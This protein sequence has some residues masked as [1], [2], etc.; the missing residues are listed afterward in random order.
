M[1]DRDLGP[2]RRVNLLPLGLL[3]VALAVGGCQSTPAPEPPS[4]AAPDPELAPID[5]EGP[6]DPDRPPPVLPEVALLLGPYAGIELTITARRDGSI[7]QAVISKPSQAKLYDEYT[8]KWVED[9]WKMPAA[10]PGEPEVREFVA[11]IV[12]PK[13]K[14]PSGGDYPLPDYPE[15]LVRAHVQEFLVLEMTIAASGEI[16]KTRVALSSGNPK[17]D[18]YTANWILTKWKFP[19]GPRLFYWPFTFGD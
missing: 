18:D 5:A 1:K 3:L 11:P 4:Q 7:Q 13:A 15:S 19:P 17:L 6:A 14:L 8:R 12:Y 10:K 16:E 9:H 2:P